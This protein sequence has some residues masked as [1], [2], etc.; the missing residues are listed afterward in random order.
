MESTAL[1]QA[2]KTRVDQETGEYINGSRDS[3]AVQQVVNNNDV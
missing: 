2:S 3:M 1:M